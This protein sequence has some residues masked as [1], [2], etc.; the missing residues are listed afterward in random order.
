MKT[1]KMIIE[2]F[3]FALFLIF[4][5]S[6]LYGYNPAGFYAILSLQVVLYLALK[7]ASVPIDVNARFDL[8]NKAKDE[9]PTPSNEWIEENKNLSHA[10]KVL[11]KGKIKFVSSF[12][13]Q[14]LRSTVQ[15][16]MIIQDELDECE[17]AFLA[18][19]RR[20]IDKEILNLA[21]R[22]ASF[23]HS[24][25]EESSKN[26]YLLIKYKGNAYSVYWRSERNII[27]WKDYIKSHNIIAYGYIADLLPVPDFKEGIDER[28]K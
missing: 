14:A 24:P 9:A 6:L 1:L 8:I 28:T 22:M 25:E 3:F 2:A 13:P 21:S 19:K 17:E 27:P 7:P 20:T 16:K 5:V 23:W 15:T 26:V 18:F 11:T 12:D 4:L 10:A